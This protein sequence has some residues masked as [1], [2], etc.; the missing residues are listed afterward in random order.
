MSLL[1]QHPPIIEHE[2]L[3][4]LVGEQRFQD[5]LKTF[6]SCDIAALE[7]TKNSAKAF[8][9]GFST[10]LNY[11]P[12]RVEGSCQC[13]ES[14]GF[15]FCAHCVVLCLQANRNGQQ[16]ASLAKGP[17]K[18][19]VLAYLLSQEK[20]TLAK[21]FLEMIKQDNEQFERYLLRS[22]LHQ[23]PLDYATLKSQLTELTRKPEKLFS[24]RQVKHFFAKIERFLSELVLIKSYD[25]PDKMLKLLEHTHQRINRLLDNIDDNSEQRSDCVLTLRQLHH[26]LM[27]ALSG[28]EDTKA[29]R[30]FKLW[31]QDSYQLLSPDID[32]V[33]SE[34]AKKKFLALLDKHFQALQK[35]RNE[36]DTGLSDSQQERVLRFLLD[37]ATENQNTDKVSQIRELLITK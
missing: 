5:I 20:Q 31:I 4:K 2:Q 13:P 34:E 27:Q 24:Q 9:E 35:S 8:V 32:S 37:L 11:R 15:E 21:D 16:I 23:T 18:S 33:L 25:E 12:D 6:E 36:Q 10:A 1:N 17:D 26:Q 28:R 29:K 30:Y 7:L 3:A 22:S 19:K 14:D